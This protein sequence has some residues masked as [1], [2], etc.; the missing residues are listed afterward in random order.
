[1]VGWI[2]IATGLMALGGLITLVPRRRAHSVVV[3][4]ETPAAAYGSAAQGSR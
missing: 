1:M 2:W 4:A 3:H